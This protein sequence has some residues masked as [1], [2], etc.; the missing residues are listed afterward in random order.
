MRR[1]IFDFFRLSIFQT[2]THLLSDCLCLHVRC[3][4]RERVSAFTLTSV[5]KWSLKVLPSI[6]LS[7]CPSVC[8]LLPHHH[9]NQNTA[10]LYPL[11]TTSHNSR[12]LFPEEP[13]WFRGRDPERFAVSRR[14]YHQ[15]KAL[16]GFWS[17]ERRSRYNERELSSRLATPGDR[18]RGIQ[19]VN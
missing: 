3:G 9:F 12:D 19:R 11:F 15:I 4:I 10:N 16:T 2:R 1:V 14:D 18:R 6:Y 7:V 17:I 8:S 5:C 13:T